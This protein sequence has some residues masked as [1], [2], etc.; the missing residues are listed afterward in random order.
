MGSHSGAE[1][2]S[3]AKTLDICNMT[4]VAFEEPPRRYAGANVGFDISIA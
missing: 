4:N 2:Q 3:C 1:T